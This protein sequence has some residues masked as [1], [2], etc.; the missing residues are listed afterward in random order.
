MMIDFDMF[1]WKKKLKQGQQTY[2]IKPFYTKTIV[3][4]SRIKHHKSKNV[5]DNFY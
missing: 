3:F 1:W 5:K 4:N 2:Q